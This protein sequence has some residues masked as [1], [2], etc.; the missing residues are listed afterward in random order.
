MELLTHYFSVKLGAEFRNALP[1][2]R[3]KIGITPFE[4][5]GSTYGVGANTFRALTNL[6][7]KPS[8]VYRSWA[9]GIFVNLDVQVLERQLETEEGFRVW[10]TSL[11]NSLQD[12]WQQEQYASLSFA[13]QHKLVDLFVKWL[14]SL[15]FNCSALSDNLVAHANCALDSQS[16]GKLNE[17]LSMALPLSKPSM[18]DVHSSYTYSFCQSLIDRFS[19]H[20]GGSRLLFDYFAWRSGGSGG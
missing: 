14:S 12:T 17:C 19:T 15:D 1:I 7:R 9:S 2:L 4:R 16:L 18:G 8:T 6:R 13:H 20:H 10:H 3:S 11:A 5:V